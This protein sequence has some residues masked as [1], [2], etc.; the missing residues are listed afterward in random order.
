MPIWL[1]LQALKNW[2][3]S[4]TK[5]GDK[6]EDVQDSSSPA[7]TLVDPNVNETAASLMVLKKYG[8]LLRNKSFFLQ[9]TLADS[10]Y[11]CIHFEHF[12]PD[13]AI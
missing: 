10:E 8:S 12:M 9:S 7:A 6:L 13:I 11:V 5:K 2:N 1:W 4:S 3:T